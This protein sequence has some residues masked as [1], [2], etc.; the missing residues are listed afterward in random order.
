M[1]EYVFVN[2]SVFLS[3]TRTIQ[4]CGPISERTALLFLS[5]VI[6]QPECPFRSDTPRNFT[7]YFCSCL[8][9]PTVC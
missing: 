9:L 4:V 8:R 1:R 6:L 3:I 7:P 2:V 5:S